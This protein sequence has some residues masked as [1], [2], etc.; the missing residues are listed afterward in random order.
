[1][2]TAAIW[3][4]VYLAVILL[5]LT[6]YIRKSTVE[7]YCLNRRQTGTGLLVLTSLATTIGGGVIIGL[8]A[9]G[10]EAGIVGFFVGLAYGLGLLITAYFAPRIHKYAQ[11]HDVF[12][13]PNYLNHRYYGEKKSAFNYLVTLANMFIFFFLL[14]AQFVAMGIL[15]RNVFG[16]HYNLALIIS[17]LV[18]IAYTTMAGLS[19]VIITDAVQFVFITVVTFALFLPRALS[20]GSGNWHLL[21]RSHLLG[22]GYG[23]VFLVGLFIF[24]M[25]SAIVRLEIWQR[26]I[27][28][29]SPKT[30]RRA[31]LLSG[32]L[33]LP[34]YAAF[35]LIGMVVRALG[36]RLANADTAAFVFVNANFS[37][38]LQAIIFVGFLAALM[39]S[40]DSFLNL[41]SVS[42]VKDLAIF[43]PVKLWRTAVGPGPS[44]EKS[45]ANTSVVRI[46]RWSALAL[47]LLGFLV[48]MAI[49]NLVDLM[50]VGTSSVVIFTPATVAALLK[51]EKLRAKSAF[52]SVG[53][54][55]LVNIII[56]TS[57]TLGVIKF[58]PK[59]SYV[60]AILVALIAYFVSE[61]VHKF[62]EK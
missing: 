24:F 2:S 12:S 32:V 21:P 34:F 6:R 7:L 9:I 57:S 54:G 36:T 25:P 11:N 44:Q 59:A 28:A 22:T 26:I 47:G 49:P 3:L 52:W 1:M 18:V 45:K 14:A 50:V 31:L 39:S 48:A 29:N 55:L 61:G 5:F 38:H 15:I 19:G 58:E 10:Y 30:A 56:F 60:P 16:L 8:I 23:M 17:A 40:A 46:L 35:P 13:F 20:L 51:K 62:R 27:A 37:G 43:C 33:L 41:L 42:A 53:L 4:I